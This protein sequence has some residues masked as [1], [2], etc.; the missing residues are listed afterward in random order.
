[1][2]QELDFTHETTQRQ[3]ERFSMRA[4]IHTYTIRTTSFRD[5][6]VVLSVEVL[7]PFANILFKDVTADEAMRDLACSKAMLVMDRHTRRHI[8]LMVRHH[9]SLHVTVWIL[10]CPV[11]RCG[12]HARISYLCTHVDLALLRRLHKVHINMHNCTRGRDR[13]LSILKYTRYTIS[14][15]RAALSKAGPRS[16]VDHHL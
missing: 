4:D 16:C 14:D 3:L 6:T 12:R 15:S 9:D 10:H 2:R 5:G 8:P 13:R 7:L 11:S 1:M